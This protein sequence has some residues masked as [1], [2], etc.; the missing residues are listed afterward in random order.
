MHLHD[1]HVQKESVGMAFYMYIKLVKIGCLFCL[2]FYTI[3]VMH[4]SRFC[5]KNT[6]SITTG[7]R[8]LSFKSHANDPSYQLTVLYFISCDVMFLLQYQ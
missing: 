8:N 7:V 4:I 1:S 5:D 6:V 2:Y 3:D